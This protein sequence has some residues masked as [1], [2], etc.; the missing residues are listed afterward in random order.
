MQDITYLATNE[1]WV[2]LAVLIDLHSRY[3]PGWS[4]N[5]KMNASLVTDAMSIALDRRGEPTG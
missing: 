5:E 3:V 2:Y 1:G 4:M